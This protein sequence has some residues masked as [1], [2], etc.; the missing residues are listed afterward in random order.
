MLC[1]LR[2]LVLVGLWGHLLVWL[3]LSL[4]WLI[5]K[6]LILLPEYEFGV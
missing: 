1:T 2:G 5:V 3:H 6:R 4:L